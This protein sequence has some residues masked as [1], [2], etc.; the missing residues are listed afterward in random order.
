MTKHD[1]PAFPSP[2]SPGFTKLEF[3]SLLFLALD[4]IKGISIV[5][6]SI[7]LNIDHATALL[8]ELEKRKK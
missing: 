6:T 8:D 5:D 4:R 1:E 7:K 3:I 2:Y